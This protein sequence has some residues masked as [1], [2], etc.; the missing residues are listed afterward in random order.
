MKIKSLVSI[1]S[2][3]ENARD[4]QLAIRQSWSALEIA[5]RR[6]IAIDAQNRLDL[7]LSIE[8]RNPNRF[9]DVL[10]LASCC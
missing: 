9:N 3:I 7:L 10:E 5:E 2:G 8:P 6:R 1:V 4:R